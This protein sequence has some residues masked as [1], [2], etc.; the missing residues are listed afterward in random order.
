M[1]SR[2]DR[3]CAA[4]VWACGVGV[5]GGTGT[6]VWPSGWTTGV[7]LSTVT[8]RVQ[9]VPVGA[10]DLIQ[11]FGEVLQEVKAVGHLGGLRRARTGAVPIGFQAISGDDRDTGMRT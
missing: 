9:R 2:R 4:R 10:E 5:L 3:R 6:A 8:H 1:A 7:R 11:G